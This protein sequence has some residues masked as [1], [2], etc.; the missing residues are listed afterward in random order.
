MRN[1]RPLSTMA[2]DWWDYTTLEPELIDDAARLDAATISFELARAR[3]SPFT[4]T[5]RSRS[6]TS[7]RRWSTSTPGG[8]HARTT[9]SASAGRSARPNN[10]RSWRASSTSSDLDAALGA[11]LGHGRMVRYA[12][13][14]RCPSRIRSV[15][16]APTASCAS[17]A[18][19]Q[20]AHAGRAPAFPESRHRAP[21]A[22][23][24]T[25]GCAAR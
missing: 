14:R 17:T 21:T 2:P 12:T 7:P 20:A 23:P 1:K 6:S 22:R 24:G 13:G 5:T 16:N 18:S 3:V 25:P 4:S 8:K 9:R 10:C 11:L 15:S 19:T